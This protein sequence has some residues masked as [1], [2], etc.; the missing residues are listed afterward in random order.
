M[1]LFFICAIM[2]RVL[3]LLLVVFLLAGCS[4]KPTELVC[5]PKQPEKVYSYE[6]KL[7]G[8]WFPL[9]FKSCNLK[10]LCKYKDCTVMENPK[11][12]CD[13][14][15]EFWHHNVDEL[16]ND[17]LRLDYGEGLSFDLSYLEIYSGVKV[18]IT[19][20]TGMVEVNT[21]AH[22]RTKTKSSCPSDSVAPLNDKL[23]S[24]IVFDNRNEYPPIWIMYPPLTNQKIIQAGES[25][26]ISEED[27]V[28]FSNLNDPEAQY[29][30]FDMKISPL[31][32]ENRIAY[33]III[34]KD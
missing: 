10:E 32:K 34:P 1:V 4:W 2:K 27:V 31:A 11:G 25:A 33:E 8:T 21:E 26:I 22:Y 18:K 12:V 14:G 16:K 13:N 6:E 29:W 24:G 5:P 17:N 23:Y 3:P 19:V 30:G 20:L 9:G 28:V 7:K 15:R